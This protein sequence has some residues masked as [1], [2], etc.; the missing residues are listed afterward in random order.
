MKIKKM[1]REKRRREKVEPELKEEVAAK[2]SLA[3]HHYAIGFPRM[4]A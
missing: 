1:D 4:L 2:L 3:S